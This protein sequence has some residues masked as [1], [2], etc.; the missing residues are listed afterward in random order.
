[1]GLSRGTE[2]TL[3]YKAL[4]P[5][6]VYEIVDSVSGEQFSSGCVPRPGLLTP[7]Y[8]KSIVRLEHT[9]TN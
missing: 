1:M 2:D 5:P 4:D 8:N 9:G 7:S 6:W 3:R